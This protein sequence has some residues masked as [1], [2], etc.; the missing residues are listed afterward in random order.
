MEIFT[1]YWMPQ[2][3]VTSTESTYAR[4]SLRWERKIVIRRCGGAEIVI[5]VTV[6]IREALKW[7]SLSKR[8]NLRWRYWPFSASNEMV[9]PV[10]YYTRLHVGRWKN[11]QISG[12]FCGCGGNDT[13]NAAKAASCQSTG[14]VK[15]RREF[16]LSGIEVALHLVVRVGG[17]QGR[18]SSS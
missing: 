14:R 13:R 2:I 3:W 18:R 15:E 9:A 16:Y 12:K 1:I 4:K 5:V 6:V 8:T 11:W 7:F 17:G 10:V